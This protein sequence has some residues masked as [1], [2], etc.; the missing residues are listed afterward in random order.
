MLTEYLLSIIIQL[1]KS[2]QKL[3][4]KPSQQTW[5]IRLRPKVIKMAAA[6]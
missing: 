4:V 1:N 3:E 2:K 6:K 5:N